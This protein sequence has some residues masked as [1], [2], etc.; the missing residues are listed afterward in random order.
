MIGQQTTGPVDPRALCGIKKCIE[1][2]NRLYAWPKRPP[3]PVCDTHGDEI[4]M[5]VSAMMGGE[6]A[7]F[8]QDQWLQWIREH[9]KDHLW[10][11]RK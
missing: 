4:N 1:R 2:A 11:G 3:V 6:L 9:G 8:T 10:P 7:V 5:A